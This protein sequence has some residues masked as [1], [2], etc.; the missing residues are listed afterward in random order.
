MT[1][2]EDRK[3][4]VLEYRQLW[5]DL[6]VVAAVTATLSWAAVLGLVLIGGG[7]AAFLALLIL[8][9]AAAA[10]A[11]GARRRYRKGAA[12][13]PVR[14]E[15]MSRH[16]LPAPRRPAGHG[17]CAALLLCFT[18][19]LCSLGVLSMFGVGDGTF[20]VLTG[21][22]LISTIAA[23]FACRRWKDALLHRAV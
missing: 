9:V 17:R 7:T 20:V 5:K 12:P 11:A 1:D 23:Y 6:F 21:M 4:P 10:W 14:A 3:V 22:P 2:V 18:A 13:T 16:L 19:G 8:A 15:R